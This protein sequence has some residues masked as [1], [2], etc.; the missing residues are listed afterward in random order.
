[1]KENYPS[2]PVLQEEKIHSWNCSSG[3]AV[4]LKPSEALRQAR[5]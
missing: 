3:E 4:H 2:L 5:K 1:M